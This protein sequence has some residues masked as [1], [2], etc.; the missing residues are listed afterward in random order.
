LYLLGHTNAKLTTELYQQV[1]DMGGSG[2]ETLEKAVGCTP[3]RPSRC[4]PAGGF[5]LPIVYRPQKTPP[6][7]AYQA[8]WKAR[9]RLRR[10]DFPE[11]AEGTRTLD[12]LHGKQTYVQA[13]GL[14]L[15]AKRG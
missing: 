1:F 15:P 13:L 7:S 4:S 8:S 5:R 6:S 9:K 12:L 10:G 11:A 3:T 2:V 14:P